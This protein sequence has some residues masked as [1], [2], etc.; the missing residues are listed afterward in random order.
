M[1]QE[2][3]WGRGWRDV[4]RS[5]DILTFELETNESIVI[6]LFICLFTMEMERFGRKMGGRHCEESRV[7]LEKMRGWQRLWSSYTNLIIMIHWPEQNYCSWVYFLSHFTIVFYE[8][9]HWSTICLFMWKYKTHWGISGSK[10]IKQRSFTS[11]LEWEENFFFWIYQ[12]IHYVFYGINHLLVYKLYRITKTRCLRKV[13][14]CL[15][16]LS[17]AGFMNHTSG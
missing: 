15:F 2:G 4:E 17:A 11:M 10:A 12:T 6:K 14:N 3:G 16:L 5:N 8:S 7:R 1:R 13:W 9:P